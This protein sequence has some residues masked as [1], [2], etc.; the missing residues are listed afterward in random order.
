MA[1]PQ[2][3]TLLRALKLTFVLVRANILAGMDV[4][5]FLIFPLVQELTSRGWESGFLLGRFRKKDLTLVVLPG[6]G[7]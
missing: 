7:D 4:S 3:T 6:I 2:Q 1:D 5:P